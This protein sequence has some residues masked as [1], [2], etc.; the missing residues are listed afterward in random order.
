MTAPPIPRVVT[1]TKS[2]AVVESLARFVHESSLRVDERL[3]AERELAAALG[4]S[5][6]VLREALKHLEAL[7]AIE[8]RPGSGTYL[9]ERLSPGDSLVIMRVDLERESLLK[10]LELRRA[11]EAEAAG[12][13]A[14][15][16]DEAAIAELEH[17]VNRLELEFQTEGDNPESD[18]AFHM[19]LIRASGNRL[20][21]DVLSPVWNRI[22]TFWQYPL[23]KLDFAKRTL[24]LHRTLFERIRARDPDGARAVVHQL[25]AI[26]EEDLRE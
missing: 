24:P 7:G 10:L 13:A 1:Q 3:P 8:A 4:V 25:F 16:A 23:G 17:L 14:T 11:L 22:E 19:A 6:P 26:V 21:W 15:R 5:R 20:F 12:L 2:E 18:K 9:R